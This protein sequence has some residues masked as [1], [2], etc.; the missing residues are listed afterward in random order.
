M[1]SFFAISLT[2]G[3]SSVSFTWL[4][5]PSGEYDSSRSSFSRAHSTSLGCGFQ[6]LSS[7]W[8]TAGL[9]LSGLAVRFLTL[10]ES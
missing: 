7:T 10:A 1:L 2:S 4:L 8:F 6:K 5:P 3:T 9:Y